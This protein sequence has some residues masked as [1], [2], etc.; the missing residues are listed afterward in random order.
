[1]SRNIVS[2]SF[3]KNK[4]LTP[5]FKQPKFNKSAA[6][7]LAA[8]NPRGFAVVN[9]ALDDSLQEGETVID[10]ITPCSLPLWLDRVFR[11]E[12]N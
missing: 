2:V 7:F 3:V 4:D 8:Y 11:G 12:T 9:M 6:S 10:F 5:N 1:V